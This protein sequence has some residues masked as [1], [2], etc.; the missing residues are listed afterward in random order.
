MSCDLTPAELET[1]ARAPRG[2]KQ[3]R[4]APEPWTLVLL[5]YSSGKEMLKIQGRGAPVE[6]W[7][8]SPLS[9]GPRQV[10][11]KRV[12]LDSVDRTAYYTA[13]RLDLKSEIEARAAAGQKEAPEMSRKRGRR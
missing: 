3:L 7:I 6:I 4:P 10:K 13:G 9:T 5:G 12:Q 8:P 1:G 11:A 2:A